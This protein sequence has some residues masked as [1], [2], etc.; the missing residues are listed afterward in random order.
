MSAVVPPYTPLAAPLGFTPP[1]AAFLLFLLPATCIYLLFV[2]LVK[3]GLLRRLT[4]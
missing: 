4:F 2:E 3:R 1:P